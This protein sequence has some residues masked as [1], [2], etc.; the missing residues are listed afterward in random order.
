MAMRCAR[1]MV[2]G[3]SVGGLPRYFSTSSGGKGGVLDDKERAQETIFIQKM[4]R[5][6]LEKQKLKLDK[7]NA[8]KGKEAAEKKSKDEIQ[9]D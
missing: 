4:E 2:S 9:K 8:E 1:R 3:S 6:R 5:E 7:E